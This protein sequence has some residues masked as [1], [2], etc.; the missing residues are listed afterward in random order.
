MARIDELRLI[1]RIARMYFELGI[2]QAEIS[3]QLGIS[4]ATVSRFLERAKEEGIVR[5]SVTIPPGVNSELEE[6]LIY[7]YKLR[8]AIVV[9]CYS[10][11]DESIIN[12]DIGAAAAYYL[13]TAINHN[14]IIGISSWSSALLALVDAFHPA[15]RRNFIRVIQILGGVGNPTAEAHANRLTSRL[16]MLVDGEA[17]FLPVPGIL[18][19]EKSLKVLEQDPYVQKAI[20]MF[21]EVTLALVGIGAL[22]P[23]NLLKES[24]NIFTDQELRLLSSRGAVGDALLRFFDIEG[25]PVHSVLNER[26]FSMKL[27]QLRKVDRAIGVAGGERK[28]MA[29]LGALRGKYI[30]ILVTD[31]CTAKWLVE[32]T[33]MPS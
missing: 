15:Q 32:R 22:Q 13:E 8:D 24:G 19:S 25:N 12:R 31:T 16:A 17:V 3:R 14:E 1:S 28:R 7:H 18:G 9:D 5:I 2:K 26:V 20:Q 4:Q 23:S 27:E 10:D 29:I 6:A 21:D 11:T 33:K 30:N